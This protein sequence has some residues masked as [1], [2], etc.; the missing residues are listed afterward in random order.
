[1]RS[2]DGFFIQS[3]DMKHGTP[4]ALA[5]MNDGGCSFTEIADI[6]EEHWEQL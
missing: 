4:L 1:M 2:C 5:E 3:V 6:I